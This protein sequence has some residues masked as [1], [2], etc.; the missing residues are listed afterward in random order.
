MSTSIFI[1][2]LLLVGTPHEWT[3]QLNAFST[4]VIAVFTILLF[5][6]LA[7]QISTSRD[8]E[9]A[10]VLGE[11]L[12]HQG[13]KPHVTVHNDSTQ[14]MVDLVYKNEGRSPAWIENI[15]SEARIMSFVELQTP[16]FMTTKRNPRTVDVLGP[17]ASHSKTLTLECEGKMK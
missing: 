17:G 5:F 11:I 7:R 8:I 4:F 1:L 6:G 16:P 15:S 14:M 10:W 3:D 2:A 13:E 9:R 12:G